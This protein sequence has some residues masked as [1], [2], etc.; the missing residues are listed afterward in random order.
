MFA[1]TPVAKAF[2]AW[3]LDVLE[4]LGES[5]SRPQPAPIAISPDQCRQ[6]HNIMDA[7]MSAL[8]PDSRRAGYAEGWTRFNRHFKIAKYEQLPPARFSEAL[9]YLIGLSLKVRSALPAPSIAAPHALPALPDDL[10]ERLKAHASKC[11]D[12]TGEVCT[13]ARQLMCEG[14]RLS[15]EVASHIDPLFQH[16]P[17]GYLN[18]TRVYD[19][20]TTFSSNGIKAIEAGTDNIYL[21]ARMMEGLAGLR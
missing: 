19:A 20:M 5:E 21:T 16:T 6:L 13:R 8:H 12:F 10:R 7:K 14:S 3:V 18:R 1:R 15:Y 2:R 17:S 4:R 11:L 9:D